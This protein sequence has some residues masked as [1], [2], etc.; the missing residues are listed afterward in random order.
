MKLT[1][2]SKALIDLLIIF[3]LIFVSYMCFNIFANN[4]EDI[5]IEYK[6]EWEEDY[7]VHYGGS[8]YV[9]QYYTNQY[10]DSGSTY[11]AKWI[12]FIDIDFKYNLIYSEKMSGNTNYQVVARVLARKNI[13]DENNLL[14]T[15]FVL[16]D[17]I[18]EEFTD[19]EVINILKDVR[20]NYQDFVKYFDDYKKNI[21]LSLNGI[22]RVELRIKTDS[23]IPNDILSKE[24]V[25]YVEIP[26]TSNTIEVSIPKF[27]GSDTDKVLVDTI[28]HKGFRYVLSIILFVISL[29]SIVYFIIM[30]VKHL[31]EHNNSQTLY[32]KEIKRILTTYNNIIVNIDSIEEI[33]K[34]NV[35]KVNSFDELLDAHGE[36]RMPIN[37]YEDSKESK[38]ILINEGIAWV[39]ILSKKKNE[40]KKNQKK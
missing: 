17:I 14:D 9:A 12:D 30:F 32:Q 7:K 22:L 29:L 25:L 6:D 24:Q 15:E 1:A 40:R 39:Y 3:S 13:N 20:V 26:L 21:G 37:Y 23:N 16:N 27:N 31:I 8:A 34:Y 33:D 4:K 36:V 5:Y 19:K 2:K 10:Q 28:Y 38:F 35:I 18:T 11:I